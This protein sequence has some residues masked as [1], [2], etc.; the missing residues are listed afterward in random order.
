[1]SRVHNSNVFMLV[2]YVLAGHCSKI[3]IFVTNFYSK[4]P[5]QIKTYNYNHDEMK[6]NKLTLEQRRI[7]ATLRFGKSP[8]S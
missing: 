8:N 6:Q 2:V 5:N 1:M 4:I 3:P 7:I